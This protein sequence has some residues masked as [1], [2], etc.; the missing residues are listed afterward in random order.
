MVYSLYGINFVYRF[1]DKFNRDEGRRILSTRSQ[2]SQ[3]TL[4]CLEEVP[5]NRYFGK[6]KKPYKLRATHM[7]TDTILKTT[8]QNEYKLLK[9][10]LSSQADAP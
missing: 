9:H 1:F 7:F 6:I 5:P 8:L 10:V 3:Y 4:T 2:A